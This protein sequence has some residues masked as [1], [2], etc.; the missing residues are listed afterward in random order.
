MSVMCSLSVKLPSAN[1]QSATQTFKKFN[2]LNLLVENQLKVSKTHMKDNKKYHFYKNTVVH[3][4]TKQKIEGLF[5][6]FEVKAILYN[7]NFPVNYFNMTKNK[8]VFLIR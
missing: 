2:N 8:L 7:V 5:C 6:K 3:S 1:T 4:I